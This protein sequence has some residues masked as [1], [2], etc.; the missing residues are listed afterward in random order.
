VASHVLYGATGTV[1]GMRRPFASPLSLCVL[2]IALAACGGSAQSA[3]S[4]GSS[5]TATTAAGP[6]ANGREWDPISVF[7][8]IAAAATPSEADL[9]KERQV[10]ELIRSCM[11][12][13]GFT[14]IPIDPAT[15]TSAPTQGPWSL[16][17]AQFAA[18]Y[19]YGITTID[20][21]ARSEPNGD[22][23]DAAVARMS[24]T[25]KAA[26]YQALYG[27]LVTVDANGNLTKRALPD[28]SRPTTSGNKSCSQQAS[29]AVFGVTDEAA[30]PADNPFSALEGEMSAMSDRIRSDQRLFDATKKWS[31]CMA[32]AGYP[33]YADIK[34]AIMAVDDRANEVLGPNGDQT[35]SDP[36]AL[37]DLRAFEIAV[38]TADFS[39]RGD[40]DAVRKTVTD[41]IQNAFI[42]DHRSE[43]ERYRDAIAAGTAT[44]GKG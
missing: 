4:G 36:Q 33:G 34:N 23:N 12:A 3:S 35:P 26:Y 17:P 10:E 29:E 18:T 39:C 43:L 19:G 8:G 44:F 7:L 40:Y 1:T 38:A 11:Q 24:I 37:T 28:G 30:A 27:D 20:R 22:P 9:A 6:S 25:E 21:D 15:S 41:E 31:D 5:T 13:E 14:Y 2:A 16:P 42:N 32:D